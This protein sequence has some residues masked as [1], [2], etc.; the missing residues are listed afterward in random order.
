ME[1]FRCFITGYGQHPESIL[2]YVVYAHEIVDRIDVPRNDG[3]S[4][5][6]YDLSGRPIRNPETGKG[7]RIARGVKILR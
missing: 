6:Y 5:K 4:Q 2:E 3:S 7:I 1:P